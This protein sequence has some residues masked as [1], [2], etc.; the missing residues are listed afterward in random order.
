MHSKGLGT[1]LAV[2]LHDRVG[3]DRTLLCPHRH[4]TG[5]CDRS[6]EKRRE[7]LHQK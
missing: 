2:E 3:E 5:R 6:E 4:A 7:S 1:P